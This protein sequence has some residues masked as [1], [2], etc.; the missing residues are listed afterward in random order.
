MTYGRARRRTADRAQKLVGVPLRL[1]EIEG[2]DHVPVQDV[3]TGRHERCTLPARH[4]V[5]GAIDDRL[6]A[7]NRLRI[8]RV[9]DPEDDGERAVA[10]VAELLLEHGAHV[11]GI[12]PG[13][14]E[15]VRLEVRQPP[16]RPETGDEDHEPG[17]RHLPAVPEHPPGAPPD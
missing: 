9:G 14:T 1:R 8:R 17:D 5:G 2:R 13:N 16:R 4:G 3:R 11:L 7:G 6:E 15:H 10:P 12:R